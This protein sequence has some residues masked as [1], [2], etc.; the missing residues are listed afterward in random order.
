MIFEKTFEVP[1]PRE[2]LW[3]SFVEHPELLIPLL[4]DCQEFETISENEYKAKFK[5]G[6]SSIKGTM[7]FQFFVI[8]KKSPSQIKLKGHGTGISSVIDMESIISL[9]NTPDGSTKVLLN[10]DIKVSGLIVSV[11]TRLLH[12]FTEKKVNELYKSIK[13]DIERSCF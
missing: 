4:P 12:T 10:S 13:E 5:V 9:E 8:E 11:G 1:V 3:S 7:N 2:K 6:I